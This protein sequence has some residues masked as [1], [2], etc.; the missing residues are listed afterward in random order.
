M[1]DKEQQP[2]NVQSRPPSDD[3]VAVLRE[4]SALLKHL[5]TKIERIDKQLRREMY[6]RWV[7]YAFL[8]LIVFLSA[9]WVTPYIVEVY[10]TYQTFTQRITEFGTNSFFDFFN[11]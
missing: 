1:E 6:F 9:V 4:Q 2:Q 3:V 10:T 7:R 5:A 11:R 8:G